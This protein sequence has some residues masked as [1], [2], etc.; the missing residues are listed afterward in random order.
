MTY[1]DRVE[2]AIAANDIVALV[3]FAYGTTCRCTKLKG[4]PL[5]VCKMQAQA[6]RAKIVPLALF[7]G[8]IERVGAG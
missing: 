8:E 5:C 1:D 2:Q 6:L 3:E 4:E 7:R